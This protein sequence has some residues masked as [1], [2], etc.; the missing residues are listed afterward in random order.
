[1]MIVIETTLVSQSKDF[2]HK[3]Q[4][5]ETNFQFVT[6][7]TTNLSLRDVPPTVLVQ[8]DSYVFAFFNLI[9]VN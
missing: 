7:I 6:E 5:E 1:M 8:M 9:L 3:D 4:L 2:Y